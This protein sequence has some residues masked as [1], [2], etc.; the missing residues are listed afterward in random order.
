MTENESFRYNLEQ[1]M[2]PRMLYEKK[3][4][5]LNA[6][7]DKNTKFFSDIYLVYS[8]SAEIVYREDDFKLAA[9]R[10]KSDKKMLY[11]IVVTMPE[12]TVPTLC[13]R[14]YFCYEEKTEIVRYYTSELTEDGLLN[15]CS[16]NK[17]GDHKVC[18]VSPMDEELEFRRIGNMFLK[19]VLENEKK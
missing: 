2:L 6:I 17:Y 4:D 13:K 19:Y 14:V 1:K 10:C 8:P 16:V 15:M 5:V 3:V 9:K 11:Y 18:D 12:P 7:L